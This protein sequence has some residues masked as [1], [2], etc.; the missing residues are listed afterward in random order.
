MPGRVV[1]PKLPGYT[2]SSPVSLDDHAFS[3]QQTLRYVKGYAHEAP[4]MTVQDP[5]MAS[6]VTEMYRSGQYNPSTYTSSPTY[7]SA[8]KEETLPDW[9]VNN[10]K[11][12]RW[13]GYFK[14]AVTESAVENYRVRKVVIFFYL[15]DNSCQVVEPKEDNSGLPQGVLI[16]RHRIEKSDGSFFAPGDF[17]VGDNVSFYGRTFHIVD[18]DVFTRQTLADAG[19]EYGPAEAYPDDPFTTKRL[20][21]QRHTSGGS[22]GTGSPMSPGSTGTTL[23]KDDGKKK[24]QQFMH[25]AR[26]VL[27]FYCVWDDRQALYG[28]RRPY[29]LHYFLEDDTVEILELHENNDGRDPFPVFLRRGPLP[30][31][32]HVTRTGKKLVREQCYGPQ[33]LAL[34]AFIHVYGRDFFIHDADD[35]T[36]QWYSENVGATDAMEPIPVGEG[37]RPIPVPALPPYNGFGSFEDSEQSCKNLVPKP[38][39]KDFYKLMNKDKIVLRFST[40]FVETPTHQL[41]SSD[42]ERKFVLSYFL[43]DDTLSIFEPPQRNTGITGGKYLERSKVLKNSTEMYSEKD[44]Y[45]GK[46]LS[47]HQ[48]TFELLEADEF[49]YQ[50]MEN[51]RHVY[52]M[53]DWE[54]ALKAIQAQLQGEEA[55]RSAFINVDQAGIGSLTEHQFEAALRQAGVELTRH[56]IISLHRRLA[57]DGKVQ[58]EDVLRIFI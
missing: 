58:V 24:L 42:R 47:V 52:L 19:L 7:A 30:K 25:N 22:N 57:K 54:A 51:N 34:G 16:R 9:V 35:F 48:R 40:R 46:V 45:V 38:P 39:K 2:V 21:M 26:K 49:T 50:Y 8:K 32:F 31:D 11:V 6:G 29:R 13:Y 5:H 36:K 1:I 33:D 10:N 14:E 20:S 43:A 15:E 44:L 23:R 3:K 27:R 55:V 56:Q 28:D 4:E 53:A 12:L 18:A 17:V 41:S 37:I